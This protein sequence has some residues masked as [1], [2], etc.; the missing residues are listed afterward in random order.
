MNV[1]R[2]RIR[3]QWREREPGYFLR[4][5]GLPT[6]LNASDQIV[7]LSDLLVSSRLILNEAE[8]GSGLI[9]S[10]TWDVT[11]LLQLRNQLHV[12][13][14]MPPEEFFLEIRPADRS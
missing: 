1:H 10:Q 13:A 11:P 7:L 8:L 9:G 4:A 12:Q 14:T 6:G 3:G 5:F 2:I